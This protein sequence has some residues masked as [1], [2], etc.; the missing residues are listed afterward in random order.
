MTWQDAQSL[1]VRPSKL[2]DIE[3]PYVAFCFD[4]AAGYLGSHI[5]LELD[6]IGEKVTAKE[7]GIREQKKQRLEAILAGKE[8]AQ[9]KKFADPAAMMGI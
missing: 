3:D 6:K 9:T 7:Q 1:G 8:A 5:E 4:Q 2:L